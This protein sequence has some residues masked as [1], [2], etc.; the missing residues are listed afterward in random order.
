MTIINGIEIDVKPC[1]P[2]STRTALLNNDPLDTHLHVIA[3]VS[4]PCM[5]A[6]RYIL[7]REFIARMERE[8]NVILYV[9]ELAY[10]GQGYYVTQPNN[11]RHLRLKGR[12][13]S[14][15]RRT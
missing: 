7:A 8:Q 4:N 2:D 11:P 10:G 1:D 14:G 9:V 15:T 13:P 5:F 3:V 6:R 12:C